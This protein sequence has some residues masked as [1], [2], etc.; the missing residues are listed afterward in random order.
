MPVDL[1]RIMAIKRRMV[2]V[3]KSEWE[4]TKFGVIVLKTAKL[5]SF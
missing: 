5:Y 4:T 1:Y 3:V 2:D